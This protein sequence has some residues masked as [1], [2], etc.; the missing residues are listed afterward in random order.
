M[1]LTGAEPK[2]CTRANIHL[3]NAVTLLFKLSMDYIKLYEQHGLFLCQQSRSVLRTLH[4][5]C[6]FVAKA[7]SR[8]FLETVEVDDRSGQEVFSGGDIS[9]PLTSLLKQ[10]DS[11]ALEKLNQFV[12]ND[13]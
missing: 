13:V 11:I 9:Q 4:A 2:K 5:L 12:R 7:A 8:V 3:K 10:L 6:C 1:R